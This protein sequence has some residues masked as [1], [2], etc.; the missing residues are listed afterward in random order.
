MIRELSIA[1]VKHPQIQTIRTIFKKPDSDYQSYIPVV[2]TWANRVV[3]ENNSRID[4]LLYCPEFDRNKNSLSLVETLLPRSRIA[5][6]VSPKTMDW[7]V[8]GVAHPPIISLCTIRQVQFAE[9]QP[10]ET[11]LIVVLDRLRMIGNIGCVIRSAAAAGATAVAYTN[12]VTRI[13]NPRLVT[14]SHGSILGISVIDSNVANLGSSLVAMGYSIFLADAN[15]G[16]SYDQVKF[17]HRT[18]IVL[19]SER[20]G[21]DSEWYQYQNTQ[22]TIPMYGHADSLNVSAAGSVLIFAASSVSFLVIP[23]SGKVFAYKCMCG[24]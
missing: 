18:A 20:S 12:R 15:R 24:G 9:L 13:N 2:G 14:A 8:P 19:G 10:Q 6:R 22:I 11:S 7:L 23:G 16:V 5:F 17:P 21:I 1:G 4:T 3:L